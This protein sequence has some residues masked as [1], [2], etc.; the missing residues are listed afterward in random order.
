MK[1]HVHLY[2]ILSCIKALVHVNDC[3][4]DRDTFST[5]VLEFYE[6]PNACMQSK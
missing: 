4:S 2:L 1:I 5:I 6:D 3:I